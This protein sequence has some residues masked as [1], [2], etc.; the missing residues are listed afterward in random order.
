M[1]CQTLNE[2]QQN[3]YIEWIA[4]NLKRRSIVDRNKRHFL[5]LLG[6]LLETG[7]GEKAIRLII[8]S[9][10]LDELILRAQF[11]CEENKITSLNV[12]TLLVTKVSEYQLI[13]V[14]REK[15]LVEL[16]V[17]YLRLPNYDTVV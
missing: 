13:S 2:A 7:L 6:L 15:G 8:E 16:L 4:T 10:L 17:N 1:F 14:I 11:D 5:N 12:L 9:Y 3:K